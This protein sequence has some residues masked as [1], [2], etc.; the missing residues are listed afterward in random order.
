MPPDKK[1]SLT[2]SSLSGDVT[3]D[4]PP[5]QKLKIV[6]EH[7]V[8]ALH[9]TGTGPWVL[10]KNG[11][12]LDQDQTIEQAGLVDGDILTLSP[13]EGGGGSCR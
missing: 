10:D 9:L 7:A 6:V 12:P 1:V 11:V 2:I 5:H 8:Q 4:F 13:E 3:L